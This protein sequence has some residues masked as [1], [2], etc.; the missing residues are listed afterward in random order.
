[1]SK[2]PPVTTTVSGEPSPQLIVNV[3]VSWVPASLYVPVRCHRTVLVHRCGRQG[4]NVGATLVIVVVVLP[5]S[6]PV[7]SSV[8]VTPMVYTFAGCSVGLSSRYWCVMSKVPPV[9]ATVSR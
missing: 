9:T 8:S 5:V 3:C 2:I 7:S 4:V 1:M 6:V